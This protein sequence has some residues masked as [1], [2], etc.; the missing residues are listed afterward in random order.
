MSEKPFPSDFLWG[1]ASAAYQVEG[2]HDADGKGPSL[3]DHWVRLPGKTYRGTN[4]NTATDHYRRYREDIALM[5]EMGLKA[6]R[7]SISWPRLFP[8]GRG[9]VNPAGLAYYTELIRTLVSKGITPIVTLYHWDLPLALQTEYGGWESRRI[10]EDFLLYAQTCFEAFGEHVRHWIVLNEPNVFTQLGYLLGLHPPGKTDLAAYLRAFHYTA[11]AHGAVVNLFKEKSYPGVIGSSLAFTPA[12]PA[13]EKEEDTQALANYYGTY[14]WWTLDIYQRGEYPRLGWEYFTRRGVMPPWTEEDQALLMGAKQSDFI[15]INYYQSALIAGDPEPG[16]SPSL[17]G[18]PGLYKNVPNPSISYTDWG[19]AIDPGG[20]Y[21]GL[22]QLKERYGLPVLIS[23]NGLGAY[24]QPE[25]DRIRDEYRIDYLR[26]H[27][28][29][30]HQAITAGVALWGYCTWSF[31]DLFSWL[32]GYQKRYGLVYVD[33]D[34][35][36][37]Q[38]LKKDSFYWYQQVIA[39]NGANCIEEEGE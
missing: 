31:T 27:I 14:C 39:S 10:I 23:E 33:F 21:Y 13:S 18:V 3:W 19:W 15:G 28:R 9:R 34:S 22:L 17:N 29:A 5:G 11:L 30:C 6:Y 1:S 12:Y 25:G 20:L 7:F 37:L 38:R 35:G 24:D 4:A 2:A 36:S 26:R 16:T 8:Q 32:N